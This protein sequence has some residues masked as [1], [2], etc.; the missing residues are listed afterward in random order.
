MWIWSQ[1]SV[2]QILLP[3]DKVSNAI[4][5]T[6]KG[7]W[8]NST[9]LTPGQFQRVNHNNWLSRLHLQTTTP[10][11]SSHFNFTHVQMKKI[12]IAVADVQLPH[13]PVTGKPSFMYGNWS[14]KVMLVIVNNA[15]EAFIAH[16]YFWYPLFK[17]R[18]TNWKWLR[19]QHHSD[20]CPGYSLTF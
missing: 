14:R 3:G 16:K 9:R 6:D 2:A 11:V 19:K 20:L 4:N 5:I 8:K 13:S 15:S 17:R 10:S 1:Y 18:F 7:F 12:T